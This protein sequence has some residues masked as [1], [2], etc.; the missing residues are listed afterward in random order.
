MDDSGSIT[1]GSLSTGVSSGIGT[2][3]IGTSAT[4]A[5]FGFSSAVCSGGGNT[6]STVDAAPSSGIIGSTFASVLA[7]AH[8][9]IT[10]ASVKLGSRYLFFIAFLQNSAQRKP[11][12]VIS[13]Y[14]LRECCQGKAQHFKNSLDFLVTFAVFYCLV[15][16]KSTRFEN[17]MSRQV[18]ACRD[19]ENQTF[20]YFLMYLKLPSVSVTSDT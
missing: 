1:S 15:L 20:S 2:D 17:K 16:L 4:D 13:V 9:K 11:L 3:S 7:H 5:G 12:P 10:A 14:G 18:L 19:E 8:S 6:G